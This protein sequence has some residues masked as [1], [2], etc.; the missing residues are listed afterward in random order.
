MLVR[1]RTYVQDYFECSLSPQFLEK[2][3]Q[4]VPKYK[5][6][7]SFGPHLLKI[8]TFSP[9]FATALNAQAGNFAGIFCKQFLMMIS[10]LLLNQIF[11]RTY[12]VDELFCN[13]LILLFS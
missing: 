7:R 5:L 3:S 13:L 11:S 1:I 2:V 12:L 9:S 4:I 6:F 10:Y 8:R